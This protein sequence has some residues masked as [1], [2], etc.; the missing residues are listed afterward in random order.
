KHH[1]SLLIPSA[2]GGGKAHT[3]PGSS[4]AAPEDRKRLRGISL[5]AGGIARSKVSWRAEGCRRVGKLPRG[6]QR[7]ARRARCGRDPR[8]VARVPLEAARDAE[9]FH[10]GLEGRAL[11]AQD[12]GGAAVAADAPA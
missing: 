12:P 9:L 1:V 7:T 8:P 3:V 2:R 6:W 4:R 11:E 5:T 10:A